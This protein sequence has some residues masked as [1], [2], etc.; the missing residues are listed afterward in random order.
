[1]TSASNNLSTQI[2][3]MKE[4]KPQIPDRNFLDIFMK[5]GEIPLNL[6]DHD[7]GINRSDSVENNSSSNSSSHPNLPQNNLESVEKNGTRNKTES[8]KSGRLP[9]MHTQPQTQIQNP[10]LARNSNV[11]PITP[12]S[13]NQEASRPTP[14][15]FPKTKQTP[16]TFN[17]SGVTQSSFVAS[18]PY[19]NSKPV[20]DLTG[21]TKPP[22]HAPSARSATLKSSMNSPDDS[23]N[24]LLS[25]QQRY[26]NVCEAKIN[27]LMERFSVTEST[28]LSID[29]KKEY[30]KNKFKPQFEKIKSD[31][32]LLRARLPEVDGIALIE[33]NDKSFNY[34][35]LPDVDSD[36]ISGT[37]TQEPVN[38]NNMEDLSLPQE[39][40]YDKINFSSQFTDADG[41]TENPVHIAKTITPTPLHQ[42]RSQPA[43]SEA[44]AQPEP[45]QSL[46]EQENTNYEERNLQEAR[47]YVNQNRSRPKDNTYKND[48][49]EEDDFG[50][51]LMDGLHTSPLPI[52]DN[53]S[54]L[55]SFIEYSQGRGQES[56]SIDGTY[57]EEEDEGDD[58]YNDI[59]EDDEDDMSNLH[60]SNVIEIDDNEVTE[61]NQSSRK[62]FTQEDEIDDDDEEFEND[63]ENEENEI[64]EIDY[65]AERELTNHDVIVI[66][67]DEEEPVSNALTKTNK[68]PLGEKNISSVDVKAD[69]RSDIFNF[70]IEDLNFG[71]DDDFSD[72]DENEDKENLPPIGTQYQFTKDVYQFLNSVFK[73]ESFRP[74]QLEAINSTLNGND[75]FVLMPTGGGKSLCY[76]LPALVKSGKTK[77]TT[78]VISPLISLMQDQ[79]QHLL[80]KNIKAGMISSKGTSEERKRVFELFRNGFL[81]LVYLSPEMVSASPQAKKTIDWLFER[82]MLAR[83][84]VD[85]AHCVSSWGHDFR[86][87]YK[88]LSYFKQQYP[89]IPIMALTATANEKVRMDIIHNLGMNDPMLLKQS[90]NR[91]NLFYDV[92]WKTSISYMEWI[93][94]FISNKHR[95]HT[96][97]IYCHSKQSCEQTSQK[98]QSWGIRAAFYHAG[99][100]PHDRTIIQQQWQDNTVQVIC[101]TIAFGMGIDKPDVRFVIHLY[102]PR[103]LEGYYQETGRAGRDGKYSDCIMFYSYK[104]ATALQ[105]MIL[106]DKELDREAKENHMS[107]LRQVVQYCE[108]T[109]DCRRKQV[110][111][112]FNEQFDPKK[113]NK[114]C[115]CCLNSNKTSM[116][117]RDVTEYARDILGLVQSFQ[118]ER[119][120]VLYC[121]DVFKG[122]NNKKIVSAG[123]D[124]NPFHGK[125]NDLDKTDVE[126]IF[127]Y[128]LSE[129]ALAEYQIMKGGFAS[130]Y[131]KLGPNSREIMRNGKR[132]KIEFSTERR[133][134][135]TSGNDRN[136]AGNGN[137]NGARLRAVNNAPSIPVNLGFTSSF[138]TAK[139]LSSF[140]NQDNGSGASSAIHKIQGTAGSAPIV[141]PQTNVANNEHVEHSYAE[142][143]NLRNQ[144]MADFNFRSSNQVFSDLTL[145]DMAV[146]LPTNK[147]DFAKLQG[148]S[149]DQSSNFTYFKKLLGSLSRER[150]NHGNNFVREVP[151]TSSENNTTHTQIESPYFNASQRDMEVLQQLRQSQTP[152]TSKTAVY[153][154]T[155]SSQVSSGSRK[156]Y[157]SSQ[158]HSQRGGKS[159]YQKTSS[160]QTTRT[161]G[162][163]SS[164]TNV[165]NANVR[166]M[167]M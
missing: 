51:N 127:F 113:C 133:N 15:T 57:R 29:Y 118:N 1:M 31:K 139:N 79:V 117:E 22:I 40:I 47:E 163:K 93:K 111:Q 136:V 108:N 28:A 104:D 64:E 20:V 130:N 42:I 114:K 18:T 143:S 55:D 98:L 161:S 70:N 100:D 49:E 90:F 69:V 106:R 142:L 43:P 77:G 72:D 75:V 86:P 58:E 97:V 44:I 30:I 4:N 101:A 145:R 154:Q 138:T 23:K 62:I 45:V 119:V 16:P 146:K 3:W 21:D 132:I 153:Q 158:K 67:E 167:P 78:I 24:A 144:K 103:T 152:S 34:S 6:P 137:G 27:L 109:T 121:Q 131:V 56:Q 19:L 5:K 115:D 157:S 150:K 125:G 155:Y 160:G 73:L 88:G 65:T 36:K 14:P 102:I 59:E 140:I 122:S 71:D 26:I 95:G 33:G 76:Q 85:E 110:L 2:R 41:F 89:N 164:T 134:R 80:K 162:A 63:I 52:D 149:P 60:K 12:V 147:R 96:G 83:I 7:L 120:T 37:S 91:T 66:S 61:I 74:N 107:K 35:D 124:R 13:K 128:L 94:D 82:G 8:G 151:A 48:D 32:A 50:E 165:S 148:L 112:Y 92:K 126:R 39:T 53:G 17:Q 105:G 68:N 11:I 87:D 129:G 116:V 99:M 159:K 81:D 123:H 84:V 54:D 25:L 10:P 9:T 38:L 156:R 135:T 46:I 166:A 141:L